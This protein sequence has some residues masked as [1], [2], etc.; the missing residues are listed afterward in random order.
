M[1]VLKIKVAE[2]IGW[3]CIPILWC[4]VR[5]LKYRHTPSPLIGIRDRCVHGNN[6][7]QTSEWK[8]FCVILRQITCTII[9]GTYVAC[10][11]YA[12]LL[13]VFFVFWQVTQNIPPPAQTPRAGGGMICA[14]PSTHITPNINVY[15]RACSFVGVCM[16]D[17][18]ATN[19]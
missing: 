17:F 1:Y 10:E 15:K 11:M 8:V 18:I 4:S 3:L 9:Q 2:C 5:S 12:M 6:H 16:V 13:G 14:V 7:Q 19:Q